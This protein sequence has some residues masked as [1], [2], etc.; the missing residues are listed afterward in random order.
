MNRRTG[1]GWMELIEGILLIALGIYS[2]VSPDSVLT[3]FVIVYGIAAVITGIADIVF[4]M[5]VD[6]HIGFGPT[7]SLVSGV[8]SVMAGFTLIVYPGAGKLALSIVFPIWFIM[9]CISRL[10]HMKFMRIMVGNFSYY[11]SMIV[12][13]LG[14]V[15]GVMMI[16][17]PYIALMSAGY[18]IGIYLVLSGLDCIGLAFG[19]MGRW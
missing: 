7:V 15:L 13:I 3:G 9:H 6:S 18:V 16:F 10:S 11:L 19:R 5:K 2:M 1:F 17:N 12:N 4:Y 14:I 8:L